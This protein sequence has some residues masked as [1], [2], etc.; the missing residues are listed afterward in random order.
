MYRMVNNPVMNPVNF[1]DFKIALTY[2]E[3]ST[4]VASAEIKKDILNFKYS[5]IESNNV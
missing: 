2:P 3:M 4:S 5:E 1:V